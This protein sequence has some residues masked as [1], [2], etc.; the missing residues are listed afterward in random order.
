MTIWV[1]WKTHFGN[2]PFTLHISHFA[3]P[4]AALD[5]YPTPGR[6]EGVKD[7]IAIDVF[8]VID[9]ACRNMIKFLSRGV[10]RS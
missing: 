6:Y 1:R 3:P 2:T 4:A 7:A 5:A 9:S 8:P 10:T